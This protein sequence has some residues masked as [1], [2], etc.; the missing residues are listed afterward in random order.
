VLAIDLIPR[1]AW[2]SNLRA[3][4][5][6]HWDAIRKATYRAAGWACECCG[7]T[8]QQECHEVWDYSDKPVQRL[9][10]LISLC[11]LC[12]SAQ[13]YGLA[14][15]RGIGDQVD[16]HIRRVNGWSQRQLDLHVAEAFGIWRA[17]N[18]V[19]WTTDTSILDAFIA[20]KKH[21]PLQLI[22]RRNP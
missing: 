19:E 16:E 5:P 8:G 1:T 12:H 18:R 3:R 11:N 14:Q 21:L 13:H 7:A 4:F 15:V 9:V 22:Q 6:E 20:E 10:R 17:R 2:G